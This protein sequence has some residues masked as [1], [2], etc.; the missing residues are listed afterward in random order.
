MHA[1]GENCWTFHQNTMR[2]KIPNDALPSDTKIRNT[3]Q[4]KT[5]KTNCL[6]ILQNFYNVTSYP[7]RPKLSYAKTLPL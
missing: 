1:A 6:K 2:Q 5:Q 3:K 4:K 7:N